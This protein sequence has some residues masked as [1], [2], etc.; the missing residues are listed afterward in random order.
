MHN[1]WLGAR[2]PDA[3]M[4]TAFGDPVIHSLNP[5]H[6]DV[7]EYVLAMLGDLVSRHD[8]AAIELESPG[9]MPYSHGW[10]HEINGV[11]LDAAQERL[12]G[13]SFSPWELSAATIAGID[14]TRVRD[15]V[16]DLLDRSWN[17]GFVLVTQGERHEEAETLLSDPEFVAYQR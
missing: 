11:A 6:P 12:L 2:Y 9:Y 7:R 5:A 4:H 8:V 14:A 17:D 3:S 1:S 15:A 16:A 13:M 10:H